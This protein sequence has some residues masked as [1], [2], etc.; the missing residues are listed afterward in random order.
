MMEQNTIGHYLWVVVS[1]RKDEKDKYIRADKAIINNGGDL[2][3]M[4][5]ESSSNPH[6]LIENIA[7]AI[8]Q[9]AWRRIYRVLPNVEPLVEEE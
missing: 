1:E 8:S 7:Y 3:F 5:M 6:R 9:G 2:I 4:A